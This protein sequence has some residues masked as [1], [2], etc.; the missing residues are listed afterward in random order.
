VYQPRLS[1]DGKWV[2]FLRPA[3]VF[4]VE[5]WAIDSNGQ[6]ERNLVS[7]DDLNTIGG[8]VRDPNAVAIAPYDFSWVPGTHLLAFNTQQVLQGPGLFLL[9]D[10]HLVNADSLEL[11][12]VLL[13]GWGGRFQLSPDGEKVALT[14]PTQIALADLDGSNYRQVL[15][16]TPVITYS[17][18]RF[19][20][21]PV[22]KKDASGLWVA[23]PPQDPMAEPGEVTSLY[24]IL[25]TEPTARLVNQVAAVS[26][27]EAPFSY[28]PDAEYLMYL[29]ESGDP[30]DH[31]RELYI[32]KP[33]GSG[34]WMYQR[35]YLLQF[36]AW[37][38]D[39]QCFVYT[40]G[41]N[42]SAW[43][44]DI[45]APAKAILAE[46]NPLTQIRWIDA[47]HFLFTRVNT[48]TVDLFLGNL[49]SPPRLLVE[50]VD[51]PLV[52][53]YFLGEQ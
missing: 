3:G 44:G 46:V 5:L 23:I 50:E 49:A 8:G 28:S 6:N 42:Q 39:S 38:V 45:Q 47:D 19:Y 32:A 37:S 48:D 53:D 34:A 51:P 1:H 22:W 13:A 36:V 7:V 29:K 33:D 43:L 15:S 41:E 52:F 26:Y 27:I 30:Q 18:Y 17:D 16:Y 12:M 4:H 10:F 20:A 9:D 31:L 40:V 21:H 2:A 14:T 25:W 11:R 35:D 24:E